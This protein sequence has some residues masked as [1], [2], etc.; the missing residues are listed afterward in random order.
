MGLCEL[1]PLEYGFEFGGAELHL[2]YDM[3][4]LLELERD[5]FDYNAILGDSVNGTT[6]LRF[7]HAGLK[8][9]IGHEREVG[10]V[11]T[12]GVDRVWEHC[13]LAVLLSLPEYDPLAIPDL[14]QKTGDGRPDYSKLRMLVCDV[15]R[16]PDEF[17]W[18]STLRELLSRWQDY[19]VA[20][21]YMKPPERMELYDTEGID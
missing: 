13:R 5:G 15:M 1:L 19:A 6:V 8:E 18:R 20:K 4:A 2:R 16:K 11:S 21:G 14:S 10:I 7:L 9:K 17:F 3:T 12:L